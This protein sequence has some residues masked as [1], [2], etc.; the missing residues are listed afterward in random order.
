MLKP[1]GLDRARMTARATG[2]DRPQATAREQRTP[3]EPT[4]CFADGAAAGPK[5][6]CR[7]CGNAAGGDCLRRQQ[8]GGR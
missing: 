4:R 7:E 2:L 5:G 3:P 1:T 8:R 6:E